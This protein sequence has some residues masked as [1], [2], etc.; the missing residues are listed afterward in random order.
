M[1]GVRASPLFKADTPVDSLAEVEEWGRTKA[2]LTRRMKRARKQLINIFISL[3]FAEGSIGLLQ[4]ARLFIWCLLSIFAL[5]GSK[6]VI[7]TGID[8]TSAQKNLANVMNVITGLETFPC[9]YVF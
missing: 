1:G 5:V 2:T 9:C 8:N 3:V 4:A 6:I 7:D